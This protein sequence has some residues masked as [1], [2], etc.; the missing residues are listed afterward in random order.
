MSSPL[1][2]ASS[3]REGGTPV[4]ITK[5][6]STQQNATLA[7]QTQ[8]SLPLSASCLPRHRPRHAPVGAAPQTVPRSHKWARK[9]PR[10]ISATGGKTSCT[11]GNH[12][13]R[14]HHPHNR[15]QNRQNCIY[16]CRDNPKPEPAPGNTDMP[17]APAGNPTLAPATDT[18]PCAALASTIFP[19]ASL[20]SQINPHHARRPGSESVAG[21]ALLGA[22]HVLDGI[23]SPTQRSLHAQRLLV[24]SPSA[25]QT[26]ALPQPCAAQA[27]S[28]P[29]APS[30]GR[31][32]QC[33]QPKPRPRTARLLLYTGRVPVRPQQPRPACSGSTLANPQVC[34][35]LD[36]GNTFP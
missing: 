21:Q 20:T 25:A 27:T 30:R 3:S 36:L 22:Q 10:H 18:P 16:A 4:Y 7:H 34:Y 33:P 26:A 29:P 11:E 5:L 14:A 35:S 23:Q 32:A 15:P 28:P 31:Q 24:E 8:D 9:P 6:R 1:R 13:P 19:P 17:R 2:M 12:T